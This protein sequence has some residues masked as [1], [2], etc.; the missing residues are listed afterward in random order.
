MYMTDINTTLRGDQKK[1]EENPKSASVIAKKIGKGLLAICLMVAIFTFSSWQLS[2]IVETVN[3]LYKNN[4]DKPCPYPANENA[5]PY[6]SKALPG[7]KMDPITAFINILM[8]V[9]ADGLLGLARGMKCC[10]K[11]LP[12]ATGIP[13][14][15]A[16]NVMKGGA[17][18]NTTTMKGGFKGDGI[19]N[20]NVQFGDMGWKPFDVYSN[21]IGWP[22]DEVKN[23]SSFSFGNW[24]G[25]SQ[26]KAWSIPRQLLQATLLFLANFMSPKMGERGAWIARFVIT[27][28]IPTIFGFLLV[29]SHIVALC[30]T[31]WGGFFQHVFAGNMSGSLWGFF[32]TWM[33][34]LYNLVVQPLELSASFFMIPWLR[35][36]QS[37]VKANWRSME[38]GGYRQILLTSSF[39]AFIIV[40]LF[41]FY[42][43]FA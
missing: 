9:A 43:F 37:W 19:S 40:V 24:L 42:P 25:S 14:V 34:V 17:K 7:W 39:I 4:S 6:R 26:I 1:P 18:G 35:G 31:I 13:I 29:A 21:D 15:K 8:S 32:F 27:I 10:G 38:S 41:A 36:G 28:M 3:C 12:T 16:T 2:V 22:Y 33:L 30:S 20:I 11:D 23:S 5:P